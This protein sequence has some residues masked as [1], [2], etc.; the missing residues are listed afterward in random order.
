[1]LLMP[2]SA[3]GNRRGEAREVGA[4]ALDDCRDNGRAAAPGNALL[5][6]V[7]EF[8]GLLLTGMDPTK[9]GR[10]KSAWV[11]LVG[12]L[13]S[14]S[15][16]VGRLV[17]AI[18]G[19]E[20]IKG[21]RL[22]SG[23]PT[24][25][26]G[27]GFDRAAAPPGMGTVDQIST[28]VEVDCIPRPF[29]STAGSADV[30]DIREF[31]NGSSFDCPAEIVVFCAPP[32]SDTAG[33][34]EDVILVLLAGLLASPVE[35]D[36]IGNKGAAFRSGVGAFVDGTSDF[37]KNIAGF[38]ALSRADRAG[39]TEDMILALLAGLLTLP[40]EPDDGGGGAELRPGS[41]AIGG[42]SSAADSA[43]NGCGSATSDG[44][45]M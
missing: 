34:T 4:A 39:T 16:S 15:L 43:T 25:L 30:V 18:G 38:C 3:L 6:V 44:K 32:R 8:G 21:R 1:M 40:V 37:S 29:S 10:R 27:C 26:V 17:A 42:F 24:G 2:A 14:V 5:L 33:A 45:L 9:I 23:I 22:G 19:R 12:E 7:G 31:E 28:E 36:E 11:E 35:P 13:P 20:R 41:A